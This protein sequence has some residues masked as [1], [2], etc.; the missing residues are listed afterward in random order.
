LPCHWRGGA[1]IDARK[2]A[3]SLNEN[4]DYRQV[5][6][7][8]E[9][10]WMNMPAKLWMI[11]MCSTL[12]AALGSSTSARAANVFVND[13]TGTGARNYTDPLIWPGGT[14]PTSVDQAI[15][16]RGDGIMDY[17]YIDSPVSMQRFN[18]G[19]QATGGLELRNGA[20]LFAD[21]GGFQVNVGPSGSAVG[22]LPG[23]GFVRIKSGATIDQTGL[24]IVGLNTLGTGTVTLE[25]GGTHLLGTNLDVGSAGNGTYEMLG[26]TLTAGGYLRMGAAATGIGTF[27]QSGGT[28]QANRTHLVNHG[29]YLGFADG[30]QG[31][32][33]ISGGT[34]S[35]SASNQGVLNG[36]LAAGGGGLGTFRVVGSAPTISI[37]THYDQ[38]ADA[39]LDFVIGATGIS[40]LGV[41]GNA[42]L[43]GILSASFTST[44][45]VGQE[46]TIMNYGG[47]LTGT[48]AT[49]DDLVDSPAGPNSVKLSINYGTGSASSIVLKVDSLQT[50]QAGDFDGDGDVDGA[51][52]VAWQ[53]NFPTASGATLAQGDADGDGDVDGADFVVWQT[54]FPFTPGPGAS[55]VPEPSALLLA[56]AA[57]IGMVAI[58]RRRLIRN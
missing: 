19:N 27:K 58:R 44:P 4:A 42:L 2:P 48:F 18:I 30:A 36:A 43:D 5:N 1:T 26:G 31:L 55:P 57:G 56:A 35:V 22:S 8:Q 54:N 34:L 15:I 41:G 52:F 38:R 6:Y 10:T 51:D 14:L 24:M 32:Y 40:P 20:Y 3:Q 47:T 46:F 50:A 23:V 37:G 13:I 17:V 29:F 21:Q 11:V 9:D 12:A 33:E 7:Q 45:S 16:D 49:F 25:D 28:V 53:T 39:T